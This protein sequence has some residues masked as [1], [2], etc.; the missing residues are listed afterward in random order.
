MTQ[1]NMD[2]MV[3]D[4]LKSIKEKLPEWLKANKNELNDILS[5]I[6]EHIWDKAE[7]LSDI[8]TPTESSIRLALAYMGTP[9]SIAKEYK[10]R[11]TPKV[12]ITEELWP[13][14]TR[15]LGILFIVV[16]MVNVVF[17]II[18]IVTGSFQLDF[19]G[20]LLGLAGVFTIVTLIFVGLSMEGFLPEDFKSMEERKREGRRA[21]RSG[22]R[23]KG[24]R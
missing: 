24:T 23:A 12:Y 19:V 16:I 8:G 21:S 4:Y 20:I 6:E 3:K 10:L 11:G 17:M 18:N 5:E 2:K 14:Y 9:D 1:N 7:E 15:V 22:I 13:L